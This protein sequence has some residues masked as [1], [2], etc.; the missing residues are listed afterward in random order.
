MTK[1][2]FSHT[3]TQEEDSYVYEIHTANLNGQEIGTA[4]VMVSE[5]GNYLERID[6]NE[7]QRGLGYGTQFIQHI[8]SVYGSFYTAPDNE[9]SQR[10]FDRIGDDASGK[11][12]MV[13]QGFGV[14]EI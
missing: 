2:T 6:I 14:Y 11:Y 10:L 3:S 9:D 5:E 4:A 13:N 12:W 8:Q 1:I 7:A